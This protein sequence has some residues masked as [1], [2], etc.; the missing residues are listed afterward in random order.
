[1][2]SRTAATRFV[3]LLLAI[4]PPWACR[5]A[6]I[7]AERFDD[8]DGWRVVTSGP[9]SLRLA[10]DE[11]RGAF[12]QAESLGGLAFCS[13]EL[14]LE[15][16]RGSEIRVRCLTRVESVTPGPQACSAP[17]IHV[18]VAAPGGARHF[19]ARLTQASPWRTMS[20]IAEIPDDA[21][22]VL[23]NVGVEHAT[24][25]V[26]FDDLLV[27]N[28]RREVRA[29]DLAAHLNCHVPGLP[30]EAVEA[31]G[32]TFRL[33]QAT[34]AGA[35]RNCLVLR[36]L[37]R[38]HMPKQLPRPIPV[39]VV[40]NAVY[41]LHATLDGGARETPCVIWSA[42]FW[43][44]QEASFSVFEGRDVGAIGSTQDLENW[45]VAWRT[46]SADG[47]QL[48]LGVTKWPLYVSDAP[49]ESLTVR[50]YRGAAPLIAAVTVV[51]EPPPQATGQGPDSGE[52]EWAE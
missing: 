7:V 26:G 15:A 39:G 24:A 6:T 34:A 3:V 2:F 13:R 4:A 18:A 20:L 28:E 25:T 30:V 29:L 22:R 48:A 23:L 9:A 36:G 38:E 11:A 12:L 19:A 49:L 14:P 8:L 42:R 43:N 1:M 33:R 17:K 32:V 46:I 45:R 37:S 41:L 50:S 31:A 52:D 27:V 16:V 5:A 35:R 21:T 10:R 47:K 40:A 44:G 51:A